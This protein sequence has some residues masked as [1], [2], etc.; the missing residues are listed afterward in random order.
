LN[1]QPEA[2]AAITELCSLLTESMW[3]E[4]DELV[5]EKLHSDPKIK[6]FVESLSDDEED[7]S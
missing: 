4:M 7:N 5:E 1:H 2:L 3:S 6:E